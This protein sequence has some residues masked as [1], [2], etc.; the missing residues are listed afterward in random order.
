MSLIKENVTRFIGI[1]P[2]QQQWFQLTSVFALIGGYFKYLYTGSS[3]TS[4]IKLYKLSVIRH[5]KCLRLQPTFSGLCKAAVSWPVIY[6]GHK[7]FS[8]ALLSIVMGDFSFSVFGRNN[9]CSD[10]MFLFTL[11]DM[12]RYTLIRHT[13]IETY[14]STQC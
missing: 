4:A 1:Y 12:I 10:Y 2:F 14:L 13:S 7:T 5:D 6:T 3:S 9:K 8:K 11:V